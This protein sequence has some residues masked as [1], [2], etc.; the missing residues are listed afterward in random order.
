MFVNGLELRRVSVDSR[1]MSSEASTNES[2]R[3]SHATTIVTLAATRGPV[4]LMH[5]GKA[6]AGLALEREVPSR[7]RRFGRVPFVVPLSVA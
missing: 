6:G 7:K 3:D 1:D 4:I 2:F 5:D